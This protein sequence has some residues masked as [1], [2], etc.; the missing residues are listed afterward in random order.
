MNH[1]TVV[2]SV[3]VGLVGSVAGLYYGLIGGYNCQVVVCA[4]STIFMCYALVDVLRIFHV[5]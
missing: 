3:L 1:K 5:S 2:V 4:I